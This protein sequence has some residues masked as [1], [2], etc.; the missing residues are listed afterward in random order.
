[1]DTLLIIIVMIAIGIIL[2]LII[3]NKKNTQ[4]TPVYD[5]KNAYKCVESLLTKAELNFYDTLEPICSELNIAVF[6]KV[7]MGDLVT[8]KSKENNRAYWNKI[9]S[10]HIDFVLCNIKTLQP[11]ICLELDDKSHNRP[12]RIERDKF[13]NEVLTSVGYKVIHI[14][15]SYKYDNMNIKSKIQNSITELQAS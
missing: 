10:K 9:Q 2:Q 12:D 14:P 15:C 7:R 5:Y 13:I 1:M 6:T 8:V 11:I 3:N 4:K